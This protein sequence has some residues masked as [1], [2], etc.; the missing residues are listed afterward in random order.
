VLAYLHGFASS[1]ASTKA[2]FFHARC[3]DLGLALAVPELAPDFTHMTVTS[4]LA[5]V[6]EL[7]A[8]GPG[9][10]MGSSLGGYLATLV[11]ARA[12][13][14]V[15]GLVLFAP[16]FGFV[17]RWEARVG[18]HVMA[19]WRR[20]GTMPIFHYGRGREEPL[21]VALFDDAR[22][23]PDEPAVSCP[24]LVFAGRRDEAV[25]LAVAER[26]V[27]AAPGRELVVF[28][29]GHELTD[30]L[31]PMWTRTRA[32]LAARGVTPYP[33]ARGGTP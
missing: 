14:R 23:Y 11:A 10:L 5:V 1:P 15:Q 27:A 7:L 26:F 3:A 22:H 13:E 21:S 16:A 24:A 4:M 9:V 18:A 28:D 25:P 31:E 29:S 6:E 20:R 32:F 33:T 17:D 8:D 30:V 2:E 12:P 19:A